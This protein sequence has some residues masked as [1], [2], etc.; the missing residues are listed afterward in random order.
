[1]SPAALVAGVRHD[2][3]LV[4]T[5]RG[6]RIEIGREVATPAASVWAVLTDV[7]LWTAWGPSVTA[8]EYPGE[9]ISPQTSGR[10]RALGLF[11]VAFQIESVE[12]MDWTWTVRGLTPPAD[13]HGVEELGEGHSRVY[14]QLPLWAPW[15]LLVCLVALRNIAAVAQRE[16]DSGR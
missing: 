6:R 12:D 13:G 4:R 5:D 8:V 16:H 15:Y 3:R 10:V 1:L 7:S 2:L 14:F 9:S 11:W